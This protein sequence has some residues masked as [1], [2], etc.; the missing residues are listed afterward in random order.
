MTSSPLN[1]ATK[2][3]FLVP[4]LKGNKLSFKNLT[5][6]RWYSNPR[7]LVSETKPLT[8]SA[9]FASLTLVS[10][11]WFNQSCSWQV[12]HHNLTFQGIPTQNTERS[13]Q[14]ISV[15][16]FILQSHSLNVQVSMVLEQKPIL[17]HPKQINSIIL[18]IQQHNVIYLDILFFTD[19]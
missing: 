16:K 7:H 15:H 9:F 14:T 19:Y 13:K 1:I 17:F 3:A 18:S 8:L 6:K 12:S 10:H 4:I 5:Q 11:P 2:K